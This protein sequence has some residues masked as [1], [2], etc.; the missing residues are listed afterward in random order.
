M[1][2][3]VDTSVWSRVLRRRWVNELDLYVAAFRSYVKA[4]D[5]L[6]L[7]GPILQELLDGVK[8]EKDFGRLV[9]L[10]RPFP[11]API[12]RE[13]FILASQLRNHCRKK[14]LQAS[15]VDFFI[16]AASIENGFPLL[17]A[18]ADF[19]GIAGHCE[20]SLIQVY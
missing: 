2:L 8:T 18:D 6:H 12:S 15:P 20:L 4:G 3:I 13:T 10:M 14:G 9:E 16:T 7:V 5:G 11:L 17:T 1:N 19:K